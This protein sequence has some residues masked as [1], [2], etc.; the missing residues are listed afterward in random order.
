MQEIWANNSVSVS[1]VCISEGS[2]VT[3]T[4]STSSSRHKFQKLRMFITY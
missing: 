4:L 2:D 1:E 3:M